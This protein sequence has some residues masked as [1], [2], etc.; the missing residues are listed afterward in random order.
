M[1]K[2]IS[3][4]I[5]TYNRAAIITEAIRTVLEQTYQNFEIII[6][7]D[8][9][10]DNTCQVIKDLNDCRIK[11]IYQENTGKPSVARNAGIKI[12]Q[13]EYI[14]FLD[15]DDLW[16]SKKLEQQAAILNNQPNVGLVTNWSLYKTF[17][18][19]KIKIKKYHAKTQFENIIYILTEPDKVFM[20][21]PTLMIRK[22]CLENIV[23]EEN[24]LFDE[25]LTFCEDWDLFFRMALFYEIQNI[26]EVLTD[27]R[28][29]Q[30]SMSKTPDITK[31][32][33]GYLYFLKKSF[34][35]DKLPSEILKIKNK[36]YS[37]AL[38]SLGW[39]ALY[40][41]KDAKAARKSLIESVKYSVD[42]LFNIKF[43]MAFIL[44]YSPA[45]FL[46]FYNYVK[47]SSRT[48]LEDKC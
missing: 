42:K 33:E 10:I 18:N 9:S 36:A 48:I 29:H 32:K 5:P 35:N 24:K 47:I 34:D 40:K 44:S 17:D 46:E 22:N 23:L 15:S 8:G 21:T 6:I 43:L 30:N 37:N 45:V 3:V 16:H 38:W 14:A 7:D 27:V 19:E 11:Y 12:A 2:M 28:V 13:G 25:E 1:N 39:V 20:G 4:I 26:D 41:A 31:F